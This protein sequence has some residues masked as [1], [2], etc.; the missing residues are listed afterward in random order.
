MLYILH[1]YYVIHTIYI[2]YVSCMLT[3]LTRFVCEPLDGPYCCLLFLLYLG[4]W[5]CVIK[6]TWREMIIEYRWSRHSIVYVQWLKQTW[7]R[8]YNFFHFCLSSFS[9][10]LFFVWLFLSFLFFIVLFC[11]W[12]RMRKTTEHAHWLG[13]QDCELTIL[14]AEQRQGCGASAH[15]RTLSRD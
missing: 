7:R 9:L 1:I 14:W 15:M 10:F 3:F 6:K 2:L 5:P 11:F 4:S 12:K 8:T 13:P